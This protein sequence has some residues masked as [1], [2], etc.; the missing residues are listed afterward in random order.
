[1][2]PAPALEA[3]QRAQQVFAGVLANVKPDQLENPTPCPDWTVRDV[4]D[5]VVGG[6]QRVSET[7][8]PLPEDLQGIIEAHR[9]SAA[10]SQDTFAAP[11]GL[12]RTY[13]IRIGTVPGTMWLALRTV[14][15]FTHA[16]DVAKATG[17]DTDLDPELA[18]ELLEMSR[19][20]MNENLR[21]PGRPFGA[22]APCPDKA[23]AADRLAAFLGRGVD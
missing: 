3:H 13:D 20:M 14:D 16:W 4:L 7:T 17:Q 6:N 1:M 18:T 23:A 2:S 15:V 5:H 21:G 10:A 12:T 22:E 8:G 19:Q 9:T 11:D